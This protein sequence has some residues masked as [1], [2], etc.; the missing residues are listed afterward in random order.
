MIL[1]VSDCQTVEQSLAG[2]LKEFESELKVT[3][4]T[5]IWIRNGL[6]AR[7]VTEIVAHTDN[8]LEI[9]R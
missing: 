7:M 1:S 4:R 6:L 5:V 3:G 8:L 2:I 9:S